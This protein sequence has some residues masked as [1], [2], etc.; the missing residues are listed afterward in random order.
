MLYTEQEQALVEGESLSERESFEV[1]D[2]NIIL[3]GNKY[4]V[5]TMS[6]SK[7]KKQKVALPLVGQ[8]VKEVGIIIEESL[9]IN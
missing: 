5:D 3:K 6:T 8:M 7:R 4:K 1:K 2:S 9:K